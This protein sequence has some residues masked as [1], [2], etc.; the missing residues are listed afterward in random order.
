LFS[1]NSNYNLVVTPVA[2][3]EL[4]LPDYKI[5]FSYSDKEQVW[6]G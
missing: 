4:E 5:Y 1:L 3:L 6:E 2:I